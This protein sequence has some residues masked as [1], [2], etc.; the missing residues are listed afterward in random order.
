LLRLALRVAADPIV[1]AD[2]E[3]QLGDP[4]AEALPQHGGTDICLLEYVVQSAGRDQ[5]IRRAGVVQQRRH[6][7]RMQHERRP[8][9]AALAGMR[10]LG[11]VDRGSR[12]REPIRERINATA[13]GHDGRVYATPQ[14]G[15][16]TSFVALD[17]TRVVR[18]VA[19]KRVRR[20]FNLRG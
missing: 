20:V 9:R 5:V 19:L 8:I 17:T 6:L 3:D 10:L 12:L 1:I 18:V 13:T 4:R 11:V 15:T 16:Y 7:E 2:S 14:T